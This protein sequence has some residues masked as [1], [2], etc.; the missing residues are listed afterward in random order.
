MNPRE[1]AILAR[2]I[3]RLTLSHTDTNRPLYHP[4]WLDAG[5]EITL[6]QRNLNQDWQEEARDEE[7]DLD[8]LEKL[9]GGGPSASAPPATGPRTRG[10]TLAHHPS[11]RA[12]VVDEDVEMPSDTEDVDMPSDG[13]EDED[14]EDEEDSDGEGEGEEDSDDE[15]GLR[16]R[17]RQPPV[18]TSR[19]P[20]GSTSRKP[21]DC[22]SGQPPGSV[23][24]GGGGPRQPAVLRQRQPTEGQE[25]DW[26]PL[27]G[28]EGIETGFGKELDKYVT[29]QADHARLE[30]WMRA[31]MEHVRWS[32]LATHRKTKLWHPK[33]VQAVRDASKRDRAICAVGGDVDWSRPGNVES[34][35]HAVRALHV[36]FL[37][38]N[39]RSG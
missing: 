26:K 4:V 14:T 35:V 10:R 39:A 9:M 18:S 24:P 20:A 30:A 21:A 7:I 2:F 25:D 1:E 27:L 15:V 31:Q 6:G 12:H 29:G 23:R 32:R 28:S 22:T 16:K 34:Y 5:D 38:Q 11:P 8:L 3:A 36:L 37:T 17:P 33:F 13:G 19:K